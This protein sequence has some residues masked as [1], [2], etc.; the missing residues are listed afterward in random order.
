MRKNI[1]LAAAAATFIAATPAFA[2][3]ATDTATARARGVVLQAHSLLWDKDLDFGVVTVDAQ[4]GDVSISADAAG[5]RTTT[6]GVS[7]FT[8]THQ[9]AKF[10]GH[11][12]PLETVQLTLTPPV[13]GVIH[14]TNNNSFTIPVALA[15]DAGGF[16]RTTDTNGDF[17]VYVG[18]TFTLAPNQEAGVYS[19]TFDVKADYQ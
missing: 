1:L 18:G 12:A 17:T 11:A 13:G 8:S 19:D 6:L 2:Q 9:A 16:S 5:T 7:A 14:N 15:M 3:Q 10:L 4:G